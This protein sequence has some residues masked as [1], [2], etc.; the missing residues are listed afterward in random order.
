MELPAQRFQVTRAD[1]VRYAG[2]SGDFNPI[3]WSDRVATKVGLP[4]VIAH[5]MFTMAL[6]GRAVTGWAG[7]P[8]A[9]VEYGVRFTRPVVVPD[10]DQ[11][12]EIEVTARVREVTEDGLTRL[13]V[14]ATC[15][16]EK[17]LSQAR[18]TIRTAR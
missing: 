5:G 15:L 16:G 10:D 18:A 9:V 17:V 3:H 2:A 14:T 12:T 4:G 7:S 8:D 13:E 11:G 6:V 1:L